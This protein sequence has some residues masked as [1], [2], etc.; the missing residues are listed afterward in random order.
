[1]G[2][3]KV[4]DFEWKRGAAKN[5]GM[6]PRGMDTGNMTH[7]VESDGQEPLSG[8][9]KARE[10]KTQQGE[11]CTELISGKLLRRGYGDL[12]LAGQ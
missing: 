6:G 2:K 12:A 1:V 9:C 7:R 4:Q 8:G 10:N 11:I 5:T 3:K